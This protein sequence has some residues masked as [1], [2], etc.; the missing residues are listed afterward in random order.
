MAK[1]FRSW[2]VLPH[3][4]LQHLE[5]NLLTVTGLIDM[6]PLGEVERRMTV[7]RL[8]DGALVIYSAIALESFGR[9]AYL[10]V[11]NAIHRMDARTW[12]DRYPTM[13]VIAPPAARERAS[14]I[15]A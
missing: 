8:H 15:V 13:Q 7:V 12:K 4:K 3:G 14:E 5:P 2:T 6:P 10:I 9:P 11:P 1:P